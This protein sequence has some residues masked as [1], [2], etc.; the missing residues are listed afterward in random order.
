MYLRI[1]TRSSGVWASVLPVTGSATA[2]LSRTKTVL[3]HAQRA[4]A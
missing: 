1:P 4:G 3:D 2:P